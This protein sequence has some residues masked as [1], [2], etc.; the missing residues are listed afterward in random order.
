MTAARRHRTDTV[1]LAENALEA[2]NQAQVVVLITEWAQFV[3]A[4]WR[5]IASSMRPSRF[6]F[7][8]RNTLGT[9]EMQRLGFE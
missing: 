3:T 8:G 1:Q 5:D 2:A 6:I 4:D 9:A 7:D